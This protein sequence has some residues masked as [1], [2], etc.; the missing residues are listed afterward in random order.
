MLGDY[1][2]SLDILLGLYFLRFFYD[3]GVFLHQAP[4]NTVLYIFCE[5]FPAALV[6]GGAGRVAV[7]GDGGAVRA[8]RV[9]DVRDDGVAR[10]VGGHGLPPGAPGDKS[11]SLMSGEP[12]WRPAR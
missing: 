11:I 2:L 9:L 5:I 7:H 1:I 3:Y 8:H 4:Q 6:A 10:R 12:E